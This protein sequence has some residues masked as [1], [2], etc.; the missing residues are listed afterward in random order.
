MPMTRIRH[1]SHREAGI[2]LLEVLITII[3]LAFGLLGLASLQMKT[4]LAETESY[5]RAEALV[6]LRDM[7]ERM[8]GYDPTVTY[9]NTASLGAGDSATLVDCTAMPAGVERDRCEWSVALQGA[10]ETK[11]GTSVGAMAN[12]HGC[13]T[14]LQDP[15]VGLCSASNTPGI[16][17]VTVTWSGSH[18]TI[19]PEQTCPGDEKSEFLRSVSARVVLGIPS[20]TL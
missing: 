18:P 13:I 14:R 2:T 3:I 5:Q 19:T 6:L 17:L 1:R 9:G 4:Q 15:A 7:V 11:A 20:C 12:A 16:Y 8:Q 10:V